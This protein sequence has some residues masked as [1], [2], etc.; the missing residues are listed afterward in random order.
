[1]ADEHTVLLARVPTADP[2]VAAFGRFVPPEWDGRPYAHVTALG[3][4]APPSTLTPALLHRIGALIWTHLPVTVG[5]SRLEQF[6]DGMVWLAPDDPK[7]FRA[8]TEALWRAFPDYPPYG[9]QF[10]EV[11]PHLSLGRLPG[12]IDLEAVGTVVAPLLPLRA[13]VD[14]VQLVRWSTERVDVLHEWAVDAP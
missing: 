3:P 7:P 2:V 13:V 6:S 1:V 8:L 11:I 10:D 14:T 5:L 4:F 12:S 9:G